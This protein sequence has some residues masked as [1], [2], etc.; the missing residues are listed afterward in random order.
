MNRILQLTLIL[1]LITFTTGCSNIKGLLNTSSK[2]QTRNPLKT[3]SDIKIERLLTSGTWKYQSQG[4]DCDDTVWRQR[5]L[6]NR[7]YQSIGS[8]CQVPDAFS[9]DA[10]SWHV[11]NQYLYIVNLNPNGANDIVLKY[12]IDYIDKAKLILISNGYKYTFL[13]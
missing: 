3:E 11:K 8:A 6:L 10:E 12:D 2:I 13:K 9:V 5:F 4:E 7:F 1:L